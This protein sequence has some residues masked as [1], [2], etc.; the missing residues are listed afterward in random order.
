MA[1]P[2]RRQIWP[3][4][5]AARFVRIY[6][7]GNSIH[8]YTTQPVPHR[9]ESPKF[10]DPVPVK[11]TPKAPGFIS[12]FFKSSIS[13]IEEENRQAKDRYEA[14]VAEWKQRKAEFEIQI[15][16]DRAFV[17]QLNAGDVHAVEKYFE[18][19]MQD[20]AWPRETIVAFDIRPD[21]SMA[22]DVDLPEIEEMPNKTAS[23]PQRGLRLS[24][25]EMSATQVQKLYMRHV[26]AIGVR[27]A[28]EAFAASPAIEC[29]ALST[30]SQRPNKTTGQV[31]DEYLYSL[32][33]NRADWMK[34]NFDNLAQIDVVDAMAQFELRRDMTKTGVFKAIEPFGDG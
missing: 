12:K 13:K 15:A 3:P 6:A 22:I 10:D 28:G 29:I 17:D 5:N 20:I 14:E 18:A 21:H 30:Y 34:I 24:V 1:R 19:V 16:A 26:H 32:R 7:A 31:M 8:E 27:I 33:I 2:P 9:F 23:V 11:P 25:K 4:F